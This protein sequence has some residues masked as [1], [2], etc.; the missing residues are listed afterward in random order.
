MAL[1]GYTG[2]NCPTLWLDTCRQLQ[3][4]LEDAYLQMAFAFLIASASDE[5]KVSNP[6]SNFESILLNHVSVAQEACLTK[7]TFFRTLHYS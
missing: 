4:E 5:S 6:A 1:S 2:S 7:K 3:N